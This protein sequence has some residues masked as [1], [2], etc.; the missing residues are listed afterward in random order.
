MPVWQLLG[1]R[2]RERVKVYAWVGGD[3]PQAVLDGAATRKAQGFT[4]VKMNATGA[5]FPPF[6][7]LR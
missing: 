7:P 5:L 3:D 4:A 6:R 1:G 2:V